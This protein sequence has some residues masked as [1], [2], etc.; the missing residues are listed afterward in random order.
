MKKNILSIVIFILSLIVLSG[1]VYYLFTLPKYNEA[2][3]LSSEILLAEQWQVEAN[4][5]YNYIAFSN[6]DTFT[7]YAYPDV[8]D[9]GSWI[10]ADNVLALDFASDVENRIYSDFNFDK[11]GVLHLMTGGNK[12]RWR[13]SKNNL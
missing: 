4:G 13:I 7:V 6:N 10:F 1:L 5:M 3:K 8:I 12:E 9:S 11:N 2:D